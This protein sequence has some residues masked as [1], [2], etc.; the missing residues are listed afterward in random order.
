MGGVET[1][2][3]EQAQV[4]TFRVPETKA[5]AGAYYVWWVGIDSGRLLQVAMVSRAHYMDE[6]YGNFDGPIEITP[7][8]NDAGTPVATPGWTIMDIPNGTPV[9][10]PTGG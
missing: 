10:T 8:V 7:P 5:L 6:R 3:G 1:I 9:A 2:A 4:I